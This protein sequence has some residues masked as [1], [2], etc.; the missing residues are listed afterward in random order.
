MDSL[1]GL[2]LPL[3]DLM[4]RTDVQRVLNSLADSTTHDGR[5]T[6]SNTCWQIVFY[7]LFRPTLLSRWESN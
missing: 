2:S 7:R 6:P 5:M 3:E 1:S 4:R